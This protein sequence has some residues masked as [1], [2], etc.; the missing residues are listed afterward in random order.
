MRQTASKRRFLSGSMRTYLTDQ[1]VEED[2][3]GFLKGDLS[4]SDMSVRPCSSRGPRGPHSTGNRGKAAFPVL[5]ADTAE[6]AALWTAGNHPLLLSLSYPNCSAAREGLGEAHLQA[7]NSFTHLC[8][9][10]R[11]RRICC[12]S[13]ACSGSRSWLNALCDSC[14]DVGT[15]CCLSVNAAS[16]DQPSFDELAE[17]DGDVHRV[18]GSVTQYERQLALLEP[19]PIVLKQ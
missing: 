4:V 11:Y 18:F 13:L 19:G 10:Q 5:L 14:R 3:L 15:V 12:S 7:R 9:S 1:P 2:A 8:S 6:E 17:V 16:F